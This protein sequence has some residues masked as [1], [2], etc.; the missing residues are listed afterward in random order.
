MQ[1]KRFLLYLIKKGGRKMN[2]WVPVIHLYCK[3][4]FNERTLPNGLTDRN[5]HFL[6]YSSGLIHK[7]GATHV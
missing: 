5:C 7:S 1:G 4:M 2:C 6:A 3:L